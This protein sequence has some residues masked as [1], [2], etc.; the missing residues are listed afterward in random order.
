MAQDDA[1]ALA[2]RQAAQGVLDVDDGRYVGVVGAVG[3]LRPEEGDA[4]AF[5]Y[6][7]ADA[8][9][10]EV[11]DDAAGVGGGVLGRADAVPA[12]PEG[13][14]RVR[15]EVVGGVRLA[16]EEVGEAGQFGVVPLEEGVELRGG[17][18]GC[19][20][21]RPL[22]CAPSRCVGGC[23][24]PAGGPSRSWCVLLVAGEHSKRLPKRVTRRT[25]LP[26]GPVRRPAGRAGI[27]RGG[28]GGPVRCGRW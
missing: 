5:A 3:A 25:P 7:A 12:V 19:P 11:G 1:G 18:I 2:E 8:A 20:H 26:A 23:T 10:G 22:P 9:A 21:G 13:E 4:A 28:A 24:G 17:V 6:G 27:R 14:Q 15:G 16:G